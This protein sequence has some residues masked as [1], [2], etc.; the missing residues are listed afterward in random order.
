MRFDVPPYTGEVEFR[1]NLI[2]Q[3]EPSIS[4]PSSRRRRCR[5]RCRRTLY[6]TL[7]KSS[8]AQLV[9]RSELNPQQ[10]AQDYIS[11]CASSEQTRLSIK[12]RRNARCS[13]AHCLAVGT[14][15][16]TW[17]KPALC[18]GDPIPS[19]KCGSAFRR[20][21]SPPFKRRGPRASCVWP[22]VFRAANSVILKA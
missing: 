22:D 19:R 12:P 11:I 15:R 9:P 7:F 8:T 2:S 18:C 17:G 13:S 16:M 4:S 6:I 1:H 20:R 21:V 10:T 3:A 14:P 5:R